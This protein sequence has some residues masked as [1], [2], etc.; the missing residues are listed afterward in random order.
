MGAHW[1]LVVMFL[2]LAGIAAACLL[3][4]TRLRQ[5]DLRPADRAVLF[6][7]TSRNPCSLVLLGPAAAERRWDD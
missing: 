1:F 4:R 2:W 7:A 5:E 6:V 3:A